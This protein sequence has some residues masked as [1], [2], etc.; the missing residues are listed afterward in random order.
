M[1]ESFAGKNKSRLW[2]VF[3]LTAFYLLAEVIA[4]FWTGSLA[5]IADAGHML[6]DAGGLALALFAISF[7]QRKATPE[8]TYGY[9]RAEILAALINALVLF[10]I[11]GFILYEAWQRFHHPPTILSL[12]MLIVA[13]IGL[14][15]NLIGMKLLSEG[16]KE[17]LNVKGAYLEVL[18]D[19]LTSVGV[20]TAAAIMLATG[21][22]WVDPL[23]SA[24]IGLFI[25][26]RTWSLLRESVHILMEGTPLH[27]DLK[28]LQKSMKQ[29]KGVKEIHELHVWT[30]TSGMDSMSAHVI[31]ESESRSKGD[32]ILSEIQDLIKDRFQIR[33]STIQIEEEGCKT[34][35]HP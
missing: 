6:T 31:V 17:S 7:S 1:S 34:P 3:W 21:W 2:I 10:F 20:I 14:L 35:L 9:Y 24:G 13:V 22:Y 32:R 18:S 33:H 25:I 15:I 19:M 28:A 8:K 5:L 4:G 27:V 12:P 26:P 29:I 11:S 30:L 23:I 16:S